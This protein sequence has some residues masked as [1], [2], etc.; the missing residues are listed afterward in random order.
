[1]RAS[2]W[3]VLPT[4]NERMNLEPMIAR[5]REI[6]PDVRILV[7]DDASPDGTGEAADA[8]AAVDAHVRVLHRARKEG[9]GAAY[10]AAFR[11]LLDGPC[12]V[13]VQMDCDFSHDPGDVPRLMS[14]LAAGSD[15]VIGSRY[16]RGGS[17]PGWGR[18]RRLISRGGS[19]FARTMLDL[20][21]RDLT[22][23]FKAWRADLLRAID[24]AAVETRG[25]GFQ[26][27][28]TWRARQSGATITEIPIE[29]GER[30]AGQ[31]KM[32]R[33][34]ILEAMLMVLRLR[35]R[36][37]APSSAGL[38]PGERIVPQLVRGAGRE[39]FDDLGSSSHVMTE[40]PAGGRFAA[41]EAGESQ[42]RA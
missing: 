23:G 12:D 7:V 22:G 8:I 4:Y 18:G 16:V 34:I 9:L 10:R 11:E 41:H 40:G 6:V 35:T 39:P 38:L 29:F 32:T 3:I 13:I 21:V 15:L 42:Q 33:R 30:R 20:P 19:A 31:S 17:T 28:M 1:M 27:E 14:Q 2:T 37:A 24:L 25:Y 36:R 26:I 5:L